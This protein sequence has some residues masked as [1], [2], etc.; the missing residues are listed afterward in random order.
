MSTLVSLSRRTVTGLITTSGQQFCDWSADYRLLAQGRIDPDALFGVLQRGILDDLPADQ[1]LVAAIDDTVSQKK[2]RKVPGT[3]W[4]RDPMS[5][6]FQA[7]LVWGRRFIQLSAVVPSREEQAPGRAI[8]IDF[9]HAPTPKRPPRSADE[10]TWA[11]YRQMSREHALA[12]QGAQRIAQLRSSMDEKGAWYRQLWMVGDGSYTNGTILRGLPRATTF[13]GRVRS[14]AQ[15]HGMPPQRVKGE[16]G[17]VRRYGTTTLTPDQVRT[18]ES[19][20]WQTTPVFAAGSVHEMRYKSVGPLL[21]R[22]AG[23]DRLLRLIVIA[24]L[25]Y[26]LTRHSKLLYRNPAFLICTDSK[27]SP[28]AIL[29]AYVSRWDI[30]VNIRDE[31]QLLGLDEAQ[32]RNEVSSK[33]APA[34]A[35]VSYSVALLAASRA[36]GVNGSPMSL[37]RPKW[38]AHAPRPRASTADILNHLRFE[39]WGQAISPPH[40]SGFASSNSPTPKPQNC[41][42]HFADTLF[43]AQPRA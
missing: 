2:G 41:Y 29:K 23:A 17:R 39:L 19:I 3:A 18:D 15:L 36:F 1:P 37:P 31:K 5:P 40:Y 26:R 22:P 28:A 13:V 4:R 34:L 9:V 14:D 43:Y 33:I 32:V 38:R 8:P 25:A 11:H 20:P 7:N 6:P 10:Q 24:P 12:R 16:R 27:A 35:V 21:W 42:P 30:E